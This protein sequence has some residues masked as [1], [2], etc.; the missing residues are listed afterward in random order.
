MADEASA[1]PTPLGLVTPRSLPQSAEEHLSP[2]PPNSPTCHP[3]LLWLLTASNGWVFFWHLWQLVS[4]QVPCAN[5]PAST[6]LSEVSVDRPLHTIHTLFY[7]TSAH[8]S[9][10]I[11]FKYLTPGWDAFSKRHDNFQSLL[12]KKQEL[13]S[14]V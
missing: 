14:I 2:H 6:S 9:G 10:T 13:N 11:I 1:G 5:F 8:I 7:G 4:W 3:A 12:S